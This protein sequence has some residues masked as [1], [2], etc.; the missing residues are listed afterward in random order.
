MAKKAE[1]T[2]KA[3]FPLEEPILIGGSEK[4]DWKEEAV[5]VGRPTGEVGYITDENGETRVDDKG[6]EMCLGHIFEDEHG[7]QYTLGD[8]YGINSALKHK[9]KA[10]QLPTGHE[11]KAGVPIIE[12]KPLMK[13]EFAGKTESNGKPFNSFKVQILAL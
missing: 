11:D 12:Y 13:V 7:E 10:S 3:N 4:W 1:T 6:R 8:N 9:L 2:E 5:F